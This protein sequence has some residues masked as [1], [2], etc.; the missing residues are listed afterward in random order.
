MEAFHTSIHD[1]NNGMAN[2]TSDKI[3]GKTENEMRQASTHNWVPGTSP[4]LKSLQ[5]LSIKVNPKVTEEVMYH[6]SL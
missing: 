6:A 3:T 4:N 2:E 5:D 1:D